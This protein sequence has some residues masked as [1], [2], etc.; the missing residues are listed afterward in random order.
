[1]LVPTSGRGDGTLVRSGVFAMPVVAD[2]WATFQW[3][4]ELRRGR[5]ERMIAVHFRVPDS[6][7]VYVG[8]YGQVHTL[9]PATAAAA[10]VLRSPAG[11]E[12]IV[13]RSIGPKDVLR[14]Q[15]PTQL[16]GWTH[17]PEGGG[18]SSCLCP[19]CLPKGSRDL[20]RR[21]R[22]AVSAAMA[23]ARAARTPEA[24]ASALWRLEIPLERARGRIEPKGMLGF[25]RSGSQ[26][27][28]RTVA[29]L[30][31]LFARS[32]VEEALL[33]LVGDD[34]VAVREEA[35]QS[36]TRV[37]GSLG[38]ARLLRNAFVDVVTAL[39]EHIRWETDRAA[40]VAALERLAERPEAEIQTGI[41]RVVESL[42]R[43][44]TLPRTPVKGEVR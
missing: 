29:R 23:D 18:G 22:G 39:V 30:L 28:R 43:K 40:A 44:G 41:A 26:L 36:L 5:D 17:T 8:R 33:R 27:V 15:H 11:A 10:W 9:Q 37:A 13:P 3:L 1:M 4:R 6:E 42:A 25:S 19:A 21:V 20:M 38:S 24:I 12:V 31:G 16:V 34:D 32:Q 2:F 7:P 14:I 35:V